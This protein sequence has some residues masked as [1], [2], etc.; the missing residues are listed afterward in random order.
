MAS[1]QWG[2]ETGLGLNTRDRWIH[3]LNLSEEDGGGQR[4][5]N[6]GPARVLLGVEIMGFLWHWEEDR[7]VQDPERKARGFRRE[8]SAHLRLGSGPVTTS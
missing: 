5:L 2:C 8:R 4:W 3:V 1:S 6:R 7:K